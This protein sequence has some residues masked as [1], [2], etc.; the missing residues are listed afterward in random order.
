MAAVNGVTE[1][2]PESKIIGCY[3]HWTLVIW[4]KAKTFKVTKSKP[5]KRVISL[6]ALPLVPP[7]LI[8]EGWKCIVNHETETN[9]SL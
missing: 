3:Y 9:L 4:R 2:F 5:Q 6:T 1:A 7:E 8:C